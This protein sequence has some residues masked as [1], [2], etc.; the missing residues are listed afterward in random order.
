MGELTVRLA[1]VDEYAA[2]GELIVEAYDADGFLTTDGY[3][4]RLRAVAERATQ[5]ELLA[6][7]DPEGAVL[8][9]VTITRPGSPYAELAR[10]DE[11]E[12][13]MLAT[14]PSARGR[15]V[16]EALLGA[17]IDRAAQRGYARVVLSSLDRMSAAHRLYRRLGFR[18]WPQR[19]W[20]PV[21]GVDL[22]AFALELPAH[23][24][25]AGAA[26]PPDSTVENDG[27]DAC[28]V[29]ESGDLGRAEHGAARPADE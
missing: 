5:A 21:E 24:V 3:T 28:Q 16:G 2:L 19:D 20:S 11:L 6:A 12:F 17:V 8:G 15:G 29:G 27:D 22:I 26:V 25:S 10:A 1:R 23:R 13:R 14:H 4:E 7:V 9:S 18:R